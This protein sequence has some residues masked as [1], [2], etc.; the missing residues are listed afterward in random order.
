MLLAFHGD[1]RATED[2]GTHHLDVTGSG[3]SV[4]HEIHEPSAAITLP[5]IILAILAL[6]GGLIGLPAYLG[7][8]VLESYLEPS[9]EYRLD[10][11]GAE[12]GSHALEIALTIVTSLVALGGM[13]F[14]YV[15]YVRDRQLPARLATRVFGL[16]RAAEQKFYVDEIYDAAIIRPIERLS[17][18]FLWQRVDAGLIDGMVNGTGGLVQYWGNSLRKLQTGYTRS[19]AAWVLVGA[20]LIF[21]YYYMGA[22]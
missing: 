16:Y 14:A 5:L 21:L 15:A 10:S 17:T 6:I 8:N 20:I 18:L 1:R 12:H 7:T 13:I 19:Y 2:E 3:H 4:S 22:A 11:H 9:F